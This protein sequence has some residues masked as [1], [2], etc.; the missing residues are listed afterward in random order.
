MERM[1]KCGSPPSTQVAGFRVSYYL[2]VSHR[3]REGG[4]ALEVQLTLYNSLACIAI[5][6]NGVN[7]GYGP[8]RPG[9]EFSVWFLG[10]G[11]SK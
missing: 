8:S 1:K 5:P 9:W 7:S 10:F 6:S 11:W 2:I 3:K 4:P